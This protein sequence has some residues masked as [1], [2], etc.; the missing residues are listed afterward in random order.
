MGA[1]EINHPL[2]NRLI[3]RGEGSVS[4]FS[5][6]PQIR[7]TN[8]Y[9]LQHLGRQPLGAMI[10][11]RSTLIAAAGVILISGTAANAQYRNYYPGQYN[12]PSYGYNGP[13]A[14]Q[15]I[16]DPAAAPRPDFPGA[17]QA[18]TTRRSHKKHSSNK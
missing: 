18:D 17:R 12:Q 9:C 7:T 13:Y 14:R 1:R 8:Y 6:S 4:V 15:V 3:D 10:M 11:R 2:S 16:Q 5:E